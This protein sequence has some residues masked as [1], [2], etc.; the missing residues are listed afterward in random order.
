MNRSVALTTDLHGRLRGHLLRGDGQE[1]LA[2]ALYRFSRGR[3]RETGIVS[4]VV[5]PRDDERSVHGNASF[6]SAYF[7]RAA[8]EAAEKGAGLALLHSH[9]DGEGWQGTSPEDED[10][11]RGFAA[12]AMAVTG[13]PL[14]GMTLAGDESWGARVWERVGRGEYEKRGCETVRV[15]GGRLRVTYDERLRPAP[16]FRPDLERTVSA[17]GP[18]VQAD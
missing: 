18:E 13:H 12:Q 11:E 17:W 15:V 6:S 8:G 9:P 7:L 4:E 5:L 16:G 14:L 1:D 3:A 2:F 10:A